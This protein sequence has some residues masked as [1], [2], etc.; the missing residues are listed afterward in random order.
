MQPGTDNSNVAIVCYSWTHGIREWVTVVGNDVFSD[1][2]VDL[3]YWANN[4]YV[5]VNS[6]TLAYSQ[7]AS[8]TDINYFKLRSENG[9]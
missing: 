8:Q 9:V 6:V 7:N 3:Q 4:V 2:F 5:V 1:V